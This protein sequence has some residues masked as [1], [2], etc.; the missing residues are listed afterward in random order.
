MV[1]YY[2]SQPYS[3][4]K[5]W[6]NRKFPSFFTTE[7]KSRVILKTPKVGKKLSPPN[8]KRQTWWFR[9]NLV[10]N[11]SRNHPSWTHRRWTA[12]GLAGKVRLFFRKRE[13]QGLEVLLPTYAHQVCVNTTQWYC[14]K[15]SGEPPGMY[16]IYGKNCQ[17]QLLTAGFLNQH[18]PTIRS[19]G[20]LLCGISLAPVEGTGS[21]SQC[22]VTGHLLKEISPT[23][24]RKGFLHM[25]PKSHLKKIYCSAFLS[26]TV[27]SYFWKI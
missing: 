3:R 2:H 18:L 15:K 17:P 1:R 11:P 21:L 23:A 25:H 24:N 4:N 20:F 10:R 9:L 12:G 19:G 8:G 27:I 7:K 22:L 14:W 13:C 26:K 16:K 6:V 5:F